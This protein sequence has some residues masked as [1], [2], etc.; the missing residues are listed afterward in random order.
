ME[1]CITNNDSHDTEKEEITKKRFRSICVWIWF[2]S[3]F[4]IMHNVVHVIP[5]DRCRT[6]HILLLFNNYSYHHNHNQLQSHL[7][8]RKSIELLELWT[9]NCLDAIILNVDRMHCNMKSPFELP[10]LLFRQ[11]ST[12]HKHT[13]TR[14][15]KL[16][17][18][19]LTTI[20]TLST[21]KI[22]KKEALMYL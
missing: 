19:V 21:Y 6:D 18:W 9:M 15:R 8:A 3:I 16:M 20:L 14:A 10:S 22:R 7:I 1:C 13:H 4:H 12:Y 11:M 2:L 5:C 17:A